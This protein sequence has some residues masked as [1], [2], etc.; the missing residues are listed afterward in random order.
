VRLS[1]QVPELSGSFCQNEVCALPEAQAHDCETH[2]DCVSLANGDPA[3]CRD[4]VCVNLLHNECTQ[5]INAE[6]LT[7]SSDVILLGAFAPL[8]NLLP[9]QDTVLMS[10]QLAMDEV[11][12]FP[13]GAVGYS[14]SRDRPFVIVGCRS[15]EAKKLSDSF[16]HLTKTLK[17]PVIVTNQQSTD[18]E[19][20]VSRLLGEGTNTMFLS[21]LSSD[22]ALSALNDKG[23]L[24]HM[25]G[26]PT[27][28]AP[29]YLKLI[30]LQAA[31]TGGSE[32]RMLTVVND[33]RAM[34]EIADIVEETLTINGRSVAEAI[35][36]GTYNRIAIESLALHTSPNTS[37]LSAIGDFKPNVIVMLAGPEVV[38]TGIIATEKSWQDLGL[39]E[40][41]QYVLSHHLFNNTTM[42][43]EL[44]QLAGSESR[45]YGVNFAGAADRSLYQ[46][47]LN[48][49]RASYRDAYVPEYE[50]YYDAAN[51]AMLSVIGVAKDM[52]TAEINGELAVKGFRR[53]IDENGAHYDLKPENLSKI[54]SYLEADATATTY[55]TGTLGTP[56]FNAD[57]SRRTT[58]AVWC[59]RR[60]ASIVSYSSGAVR[61]DL[62]SGEFD[63]PLSVCNGATQ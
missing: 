53:L 13:K 20:Q 45:M 23:R 3:I 59:L 52:P 24:W 37:K 25:L 9:A 39:P 15:D 48:R 30:E 58:G 35:T 14:D 19:D 28:L 55:L 17:V 36:A 22:P 32:V 1:K 46:G 4:Y 18:L 54:A 7:T 12:S 44:A 6:A 38:E 43:E 62:K 47:Y 10:Y 60:N 27:D 5:V 26:S 34:G 31:R 42:S 16:D 11:R 61:F 56:D 41:P 29:A 57:G 63:Q 2:A 21:P 40:A 33:V 50:N 51:F 8:N 49:L